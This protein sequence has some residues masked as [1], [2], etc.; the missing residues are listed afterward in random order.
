MTHDLDTALALLGGL[1]PNRFMAR[2]WQR[3][4]L[5]VRAAIDPCELAALADL[6]TIR[7]LAGDDDVESRLVTGPR[8]EGSAGGRDPTGW[9]LK[10]GPFRRLPTL[11]RPGWTLL[12]QGVDLHLD[13]GRALLDR[14]RF[15]A[16]ARL[17]DL[18]I[19]V[20]SD[21]GGVGAHVDSYDVFLL[22]LV[23]RRRWSVAPPRQSVAGDRDDS[24]ASALRHL[25]AF[26]PDQ[27]WLLD[28][29]DLLYLPPGWGHDGVAEGPCL[30][31]SIGFRSPSP[32][33]WLAALHER[34]DDEAGDLPALAR[35]FRDREGRASARPGE[36]PQALA[37]HLLDWQRHWQ[38]PPGL[39]ER[40]LG[41]L[42][43]EPKPQVWFDGDD[44][45]DLAACAGLVADR[46]SRLLYRGQH[47][48]I[49]GEVVTPPAR[50]RRLLQQFADHRRLDATGLARALR[51]PWLTDTLATWLA[52]GW[53]HGST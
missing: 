32:A 30:T 15:V 50:S 4:P 28:A 47:C 38:P 39:A 10:Q 11:A 13:A 3:R 45:A 36:I 21:G 42:L 41:C 35:P 33:Q 23:G 31:A 8:F 22:Q 46:R 7:R 9:S 18:M 53:I 6:A 19:S 40:A 44:E 16:D 49:N 34:L 25:S 14:F 1:S 37:N 2:H 26:N 29:G 20:A 17:D 5:C 52:A 27:E 24:P 12:V 51:D 48:F 43:T